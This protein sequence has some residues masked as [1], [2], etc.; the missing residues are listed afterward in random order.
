MP[1]NTSSLLTSYNL[2]WEVSIQN[3]S[4]DMVLDIQ[5]ISMF[6]QNLI[7]YLTI[8][9]ERGQLSFK[10]LP[11]AIELGNLYPEEIITMKFKL[12]KYIP[13]NELPFELNFDTK[14]DN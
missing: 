7:Y 13:L 5:F 2:E 10:D 8:F 6:S 11:P 3:T 9:R 14:K 4:E 1:I 12:Q